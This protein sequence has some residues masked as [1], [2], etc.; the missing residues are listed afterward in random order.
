MSQVNAIAGAVGVSGNNVT[1]GG[2]VNSNGFSINC[3]NRIKTVSA[4]AYSSINASLDADET[5]V[6]ICGAGWHVCNADEAQVYGVA[7]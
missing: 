7:Y 1:V 4:R 5:G 2:T 3:A 6:P